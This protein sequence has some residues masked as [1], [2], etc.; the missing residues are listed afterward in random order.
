M[1]DRFYDSTT[2]YQ[3]YVGS[4]NVED[5]ERVNKIAVGECEPDLTLLLDM[6]VPKALERLKSRKLPFTDNF[7]ELPMEFHQKVR[8]GY[9]AQAQK[10]PQRIKII[11]AANNK[12]SVSFAIRHT[13]LQ[14][15]AKELAPGKTV[16]PAPVA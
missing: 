13:L 11:D 10:Y 6:E 9:L 5:V 8:D 4:L 15:F 3:G 7:D 14:K 16:A 1:S 12:E 2:I